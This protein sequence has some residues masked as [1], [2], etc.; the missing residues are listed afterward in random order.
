MAIFFEIIGCIMKM[1]WQGLKAAFSFHQ[2]VQGF[3]DKLKE[4]LG[5]GV[6]Y[7]LLGQFVAICLMIAIIILEFFVIKF[8]VKKLIQE[9][10]TTK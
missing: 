4:G 2:Q 6:I 3:D 9:F 8:I 5:F 7:S 1:F 10:K